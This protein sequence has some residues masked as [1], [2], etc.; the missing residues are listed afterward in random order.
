MFSMLILIEINLKIEFRNY[1]EKYLFKMKKPDSLSFIS[2]FLIDL[3]K[4]SSEYFDDAG[5]KDEGLILAASLPVNNNKFIIIK[6]S[7]NLSYKP[8][9]IDRHS[10]SI[11]LILGL[12]FSCFLTILKIN[13]G[14][15]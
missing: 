10:L 8:F 13:A 4:P 2:I 9:K 7:I 3:A 12:S 6:Q 15:N 1:F 11:L 5:V 14:I